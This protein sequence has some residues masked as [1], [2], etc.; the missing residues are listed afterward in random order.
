[1]TCRSCGATI[2]DKAIVCYRC[3]TPTALPAELSARAKAG[4]PPRRPAWFVVPIILAIIALGIWL[5]PRTQPGVPRWVAWTVL[6]VVTAATVL[7]ARRRR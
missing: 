6:V 5:I 3:G 7:F 2:A 1:V 4:R